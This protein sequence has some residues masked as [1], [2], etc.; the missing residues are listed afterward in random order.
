VRFSITHRF[1]E[2][3]LEERGF[4]RNLLPAGTSPWPELRCLTLLGTRGDIAAW[5]SRHLSQGHRAIPLPTTQVVEQAPMIAQLF[6]QMGAEIAD[7]VRPGP[8]LLTDPEKKSF[9]VFHVPEAKGSASIPAQQE[10]VE[11][12]RIASVVGFGGALPWG[13]LFA[14][15]LFS[16]EHIPADS[17]SRFRTLAIDV[18][19]KTRGFAESQVFDADAMGDA[20]ASAGANSLPAAIEL[21]RSGDPATFRTFSDSKGVAWK[22]WAVVPT[23]DELASLNTK[24][25]TE[26][27][28][29]DAWQQGWLLFESDSESRRLRPIPDKWESATRV[30]LDAMCRRA[31]PVKQLT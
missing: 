7:V 12:H 25:R 31:K 17:A 11:K 15:I 21:T 23:L 30:D 18:R 16:H 13:E 22:V 3:P 4:A 28:E 9:N 19:A 20:P 2:L 6:K 8:R 10:F 1:A 5:N 26:R 29:N 24:R 14:V 27:N